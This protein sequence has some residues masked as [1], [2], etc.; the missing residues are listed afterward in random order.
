M[1]PFRED[2][3]AAVQE[4]KATGKPVGLMCIAPV[5][6]A[7]L[8]GEGVQCTIGNDA[9]TASA[10]EATGAVHQ[11]ASVHEVVVDSNNKLVTTPAYMLAG[12][13]SEA[14]TG[15]FRLVDSVLEIC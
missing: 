12:S 10:L 13:I 9:D 14:S 3:K 7:K 4:F 1:W 2:V 15:V 6:S 8:F 5:M 11:T